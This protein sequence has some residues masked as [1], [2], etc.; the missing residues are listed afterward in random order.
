MDEI[1]KYQEGIANYRKRIV[2]IITKLVIA[3]TGGSHNHQ[4]NI[5]IS[6][7][8]NQCSTCFSHIAGTF[9]KVFIPYDIMTTGRMLCY[10]CVLYYD[11]CLAFVL[12]ESSQKKLIIGEICVQREI[13][14]VSPLIFTLFVDSHKITS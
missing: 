3:Y 2:L 4:C 8:P 14:D 1:I 5:P 13:C 11:V 12:K 7:T 10:D 6:Y 9:S